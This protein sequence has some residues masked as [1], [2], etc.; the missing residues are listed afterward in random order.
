MFRFTHIT[1]MQS[2]R[3]HYRHV[4]LAACTTRKSVHRRTHFV[5]SLT[6]QI[7]VY[8]FNDNGRHRKVSTVPQYSIRCL[9]T[10]TN[11]L[12]YISYLGLS[13]YQMMNLRFC[14]WCSL[15]VSCLSF[16]SPPLSLRGIW[17]FWF[18]PRSPRLSMLHTIHAHSFIPIHRICNQ[19]ILAI[20]YFSV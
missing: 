7:A 20:Y 12:R 19:I 13:K 14:R 3:G 2:S 15:C 11:C 10:N 18:R 17:S 16:T 8:A 6:V 9:D 4:V 1:K 5:V